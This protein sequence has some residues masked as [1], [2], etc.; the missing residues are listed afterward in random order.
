[1]VGLMS[2][3]LFDEWL[4]AQLG[5]FAQLVQLHFDVGHWFIPFVL[6]LCLVHS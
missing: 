1:M 4:K 5:L 2:M 6:H 3:V